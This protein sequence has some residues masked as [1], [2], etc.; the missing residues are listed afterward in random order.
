MQK[1]NIT[2]EN[3]LKEEQ[4]KDNHFKNQFKKAFESFYRHPQTMM[5][6][7]VATGIERANICWYCRTMRKAGTIAV[8][9]RTRCSITNYFAKKLTTN[10]ELFPKQI[11]LSLF[12]AREGNNYE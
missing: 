8:F 10:P 11:Q 12:D 5:E 2:P 4:G 7:S 3:S 6:L 9:T 1:H